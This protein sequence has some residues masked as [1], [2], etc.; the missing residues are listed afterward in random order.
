[1]TEIDGEVRLG[2]VSC[3]KFEEDIKLAVLFRPVLHIQYVG[4]IC[5]EK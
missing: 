1:M 4:I 3:T 5:E 2:K